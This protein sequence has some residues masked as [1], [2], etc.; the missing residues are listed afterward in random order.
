MSSRKTENDATIAADGLSLLCHGL[1]AEDF[2]THCFICTLEEI[3]KADT[4]FIIILII[5]L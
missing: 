1:N 5:I 4:M 3:H 2:C